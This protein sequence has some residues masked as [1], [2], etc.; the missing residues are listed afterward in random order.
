M[1]SKQVNK[2]ATVSIKSSG[3][4]YYTMTING[5]FVGNYDTVKEAADEYE[6]MQE[7]S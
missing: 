4:G 3:L 5:V 6:R 2:D 1:G 7:A